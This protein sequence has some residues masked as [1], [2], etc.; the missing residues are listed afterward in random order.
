[1]GIFTN[2]FAPKVQ[3]KPSGKKEIALLTGGL[4]FD[5]E[6]AGVEQYQR[7]LEVIGGPRVARG[8]NRFETAQLILEDRN[9]RDPNTVRVLIRG[10][11]VGC[12]HPED[13]L[14]YRHHLAVKGTPNADGQCQAAVRGGWIS[15]DGRTGDYEVWLDLTL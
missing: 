14:R 11:Q 12:L 5:L 6:V 3:E 8:I 9:P 4:R 13:A 15:S 7:A 1:M 2:L 10:K